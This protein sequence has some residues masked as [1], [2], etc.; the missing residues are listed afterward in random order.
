MTGFQDERQRTRLAGDV[1][2]VFLRQQVFGN[3]LVWACCRLLMRA[4]AAD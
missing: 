3:L 4:G 1:A 2:A